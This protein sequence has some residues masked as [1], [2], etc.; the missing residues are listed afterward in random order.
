MFSIISSE[1]INNEI[2][3]LFQDFDK[4][5]SIYSFAPEIVNPKISLKNSL[6][7]LFTNSNSKKGI[8]G[9]VKIAQFK[10]DPQKERWF[11]IKRPLYKSDIWINVNIY[12]LNV[13]ASIK[14]NNHPNFMKV[15][16]LVVKDSKKDKYQKPYLILEYIKG[17]PMAEFKNPPLEKR[18][19]LLK[20]LKSALMHLF[21]IRIFPG[22]AHTRNILITE[23]NSLKFIDFDEWIEST[24][25]SRENL[26]NELFNIAINVKHIL[27]F[28]NNFNLYNFKNV[29]DTRQ[30]LEES[31][32][33][34]INQDRAFISG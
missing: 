34:L 2:Q 26:C 7:Y 11:A 16:G 9:R 12:K 3:T 22:D 24:Q 18:I 20:Q 23:D 29:I 5:D 28:E 6:Q 10:N 25:A 32:N 17:I 4:A 21:D 15:H 1:E 27:T 13:K 33:F 30:T 14:I 19:S 31:I 8:T